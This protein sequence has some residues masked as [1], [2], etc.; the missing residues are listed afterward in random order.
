MIIINIKLYLKICIEFAKIKA[1]KWFV[2]HF[3]LC[4]N[5]YAGKICYSIN[6][7]IKRGFFTPLLI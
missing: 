4:H 3:Y 7:D 2:I 5:K 6:C 1:T